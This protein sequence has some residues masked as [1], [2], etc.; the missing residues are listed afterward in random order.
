MLTPQV[1]YYRV[2]EEKLSG[3]FLAYAFR[4]PVFQANMKSQAQQSTRPYIGVTA[5]R[6][7]LIKWHPKPIQDMIVGVLRPYDDLIENNRRRIALLEEAVRLLY[8]EWFVHFRFPGH[9]HVKIVDGIP[10][11]WDKLNV[12]EVTD[13]ISRGITPK[14]DEESAGLAVNQRCIRDSKINLELARRQSKRVPDEKQIRKFD[15]LINSTG[16]GTLGRVAQN[17]HELE[18]LTVD[19]HVTIVRPNSRVRPHLFGIAMLDKQGFIGTLGRGATGQTELSRDDVGDIEFILA[20]SP[21]QDEFE[22]YAEQIARQIYV[23]FSQSAELAQA[24]DLLLPR[25]MDGRLE[26]AA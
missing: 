17:F 12:R 16:V 19:S 6:R 4:E 10:A 18:N 14:Y 3:D 23:L 7:L 9:E 22:A 8:R 25:L 26:V 1:T 20:P 13:F 21:L 5:Q 15:V 24:R 2:N 11:G